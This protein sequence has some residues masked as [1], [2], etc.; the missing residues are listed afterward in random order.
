MLCIGDTTHHMLPTHAQGGCAALEDGAALET[1]FSPNYYSHS[2]ENLEK[3]LELYQALRL[4]RSATTQILSSTNPKLTM[5][6]LAEKEREMRQ[7]YKGEL[8][9]WPMGCTSWSPPLREFFY[10]Y[11]ILPEAEKAVK[12]EIEGKTLDEAGVKWF[13]GVVNEQQGLAAKMA[14]HA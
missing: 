8:V 4:P 7:F 14:G 9:D 6:G 3:R 5:D 11:N 1:F 2:A 13:G 10:N 12:A